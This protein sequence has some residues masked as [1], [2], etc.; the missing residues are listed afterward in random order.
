MLRDDPLR[1][2]DAVVRMD[3]TSG[4]RRASRSPDGTLRDR[5]TANAIVHK[6]DES[7]NKNIEVTI[8]SNARTTPGN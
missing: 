6:T 2:G 4:P 3:V 5:S 1:S 8:V 7:Q